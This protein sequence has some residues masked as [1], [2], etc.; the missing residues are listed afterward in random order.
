MMM[1]MNVRTTTQCINCDS[2][3][4]LTKIKQATAISTYKY[5][6]IATKPGKLRL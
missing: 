1:M 2:Y 3:K 6:F 4:V 5:Y